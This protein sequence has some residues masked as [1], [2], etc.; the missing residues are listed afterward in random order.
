MFVTFK[1]PDKYF[2][3][4][5]K[6]IWPKPQKLLTKTPDHEKNGSFFLTFLCLHGM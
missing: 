4:I 6:P 3:S 5:K 2:V 1:R